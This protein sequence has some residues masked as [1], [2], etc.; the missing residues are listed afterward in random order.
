MIPAGLPASVNSHIPAA[1]RQSIAPYMRDPNGTS[2]AFNATFAQFDLYTNDTATLFPSPAVG[3]LTWYSRLNS[4]L[5]GRSIN[6]TAFR[7]S[8]PANTSVPVQ[9]I[10]WTLN[11]PAGVSGVTF[12]RFDWNGTAGTGTAARYQLYNSSKPV[13]WIGATKTNRTFVGGQ[14]VNSTGGTPLACA[15]RDECYDISRLIGFNVTLSFTFNSTAIGKGLK[16]QVS[17]IEVASTQTCTALACPAQASS[18]SMVPGANSTEIFHTGK[19]PLSYNSTVTYPKP[20]VANQSLVHTWRNMVVSFYLPASYRLVNITLNASIVA[21]APY[22]FSRGPCTTPGCTASTYLSLN[23]TAPNDKVANGIALVQVKSINAITSLK[24]ILGGVETDFWT[25]GENIT[26]RVVNQPGVNTTGP[27]NIWFTDKNGIRLGNVTVAQVAER[28]A[29]NYT[30]T[31]PS[32]PTGNWSITSTF[33]N[34]YDYGILSHKFRIEEIRLNSGFT[35]NGGAGNGTALNV[36]GTLSYASNSSAASGVDA[37]VFAIDAGSRMGMAQSKGTTSPVGL[38]ISTI[39]LVGGVFSVGQSITMYFS[40]VN[41]SQQQFSANLTIE[42]EWNTG[43]THGVNA[44]F[45]LTLGDE[46]FLSATLTTPVVYKLIATITRTGV[47]LQVQS[48]QT[49]NQKTINM[50]PGTSPVPLLR[51]HFGL[52]KMTVRSKNLAPQTFT[53][54]AESPPYAYLLYGSLIPSRYLAFSQTITT[55]ANGNFSTSIISDQLLAAKNLVLIVLARHANGIVLGDSSLNPTAASD[56]TTLTPTADVPSEVGVKQSVSVTLHLRSNA[57]KVTITLTVNLD[58]TGSTNL[59]TVR[60]LVTIPPGKDIPILLNFISPSTSGTYLLTFSS[61]Q[62]AAPFL[63]KTIQVSIVPSNLQPLIPLV[64]GLVFALVVLAVYL[65]RRPPSEP[66]PEGKPKPTSGKPS[67]PQ[68]G[69][70]SSK[71]LTR[72]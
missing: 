69:Q 41:P 30:L 12:L 39:T 60:Q 68:T 10:N 67:K 22:P 37:T 36:Q 38:Y 9:N 33:I 66:E 57:T 21:P 54:S 58:V 70:P 24:T 1:T 55:Q 40:L 13:L 61:G 6:G 23:M 27:E 48:L 29:A 14:P 62:Y 53:Q 49:N 8:I 35:Y 59:P 20:R 26:A 71:S 2:V 28:G 34:G 19:L 72:S 3:N 7:Y 46:P 44:T 4:T 51:Q 15:A 32:S 16:V 42:H 47:Q 18:H 25:P 64:I 63:A 17:N 43:Q 45:S 31:L 56:S 52:F 5:N 11:I 50:S 65:L